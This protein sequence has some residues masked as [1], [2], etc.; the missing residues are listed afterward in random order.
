MDALVWLAFLGL[1]IVPLSHVPL[2]LSD[3]DCG[4]RGAAIFLCV[5]LSPLVLAFCFLTWLMIKSATA[6]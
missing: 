2:I 6:L 4:N 5:L 3:W 1:L